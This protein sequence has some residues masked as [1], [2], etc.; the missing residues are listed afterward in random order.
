[1]PRLSQG[2]SN[3]GRGDLEDKLKILECEEKISLGEVS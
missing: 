1:M 2:I 3:R